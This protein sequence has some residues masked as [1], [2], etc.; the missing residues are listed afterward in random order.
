MNMVRCLTRAAVVL[1]CCG[2]L[3]PQGVQ[4]AGPSQAAARDVAL[5]QTGSLQG[6]LL[7]SAGHPLEGAVVSVR[8]AG[9]EVGRAVSVA[10]GSFEVA[11]LSS[12]A[13]QVAVGQQAADIRVWS[14]EIAPPTAQSQALLVVGNATRGQ[15]YCPPA[16]APHHGFFGLDFITL[17]TL[18]A[19]VGAVVIS[20][21]TLSKVN[22]IDDRLDEVISP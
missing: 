12:G 19:A 11:G 9:Q 17:T 1:A 14:Q 22:D 2:I 4:A 16:A 20:A 7:D 15:E 5:N 8:Q 3:I 10:N 18:T 6:V 13:Y 21:I